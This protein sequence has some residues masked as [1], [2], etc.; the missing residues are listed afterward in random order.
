MRILAFSKNLAYNVGGAE[1]SLRAVIDQRS[2]LDDITIAS[3]KGV[4]SFNAK[5]HIV[6]SNG[7]EVLWLEPKVLMSTF[8]YNEYLLN[9]GK[10]SSF[11]NAQSDDYD[12][13]WAQNLWAPAAINAFKGST[14]Y[15]ARDETFLNI[16]ANHH[17]GLL[18]Y[19]KQF[20]N[21]L[22]FPG[23]IS[24]ISDNEAAIEKSDRVIA[25]SQF[26][27]T[28]IKRKF[29]RECEVVLPTINEDELIGKYSLVKDDVQPKDKGVVLLGDSLVKGVETVKRLALEL[30]KV[31]FY[32]FGREISVV[33]CEGNISYMPWV[34][35]PEQAFKYARVVV[36]PSIWIEAYGRVAAEA[37]ALDIPCIVTNTGGLPEAVGYREEFIGRDYSDMKTKLLRLLK[38][39]E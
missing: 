2:G 30:P 21:L 29:G 32:I 10:V 6:E 28:Q 36:A 19:A 26:M 35:S 34:K 3:V 33:M 14:V 25:N 23:Y 17:Q 12:E 13:L 11:F 4:N 15:F 8:F 27:S 31:K 16:R 39:H 5:N 7:G 1:K 20:Y 24:Y 18:Y 22:D 37:L 9:R 38:V